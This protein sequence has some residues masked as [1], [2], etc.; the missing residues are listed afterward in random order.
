MPTPGHLAVGFG[1]PLQENTAEACF[2]HQELELENV[3]G[4]DYLLS[5]IL[6]KIHQLCSA[7]HLHSGEANNWRARLR[8]GS[9]A[10]TRIC[11][12]LP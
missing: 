11:G 6:N 4:R 10:P 1:I 7:G 5:V 9:V 12:W 2:I 3:A 8:L